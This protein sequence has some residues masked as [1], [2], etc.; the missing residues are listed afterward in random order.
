MTNEEVLRDFSALPP[1]VQQM[2]ADF[3]SFLRLRYGSL[4]TSHGLAPVNLSVNL[5]NEPF[6]G[7]WRDREEM[8]DSSSWVRQLREQEWGTDN[9]LHH[10]GHGHSD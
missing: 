5:M 6:I 10:R 2:A 9:G 8:K 1:E 7:M 3:I 4:P